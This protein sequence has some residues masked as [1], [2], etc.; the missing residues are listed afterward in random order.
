[1]I[2]LAKSIVLLSLDVCCVTF[3]IST[4]YKNER[5]YYLFHFSLQRQ[6]ICLLFARN[7]KVIIRNRQLGWRQVPT[8]NAA[9][10]P[11]AERVRC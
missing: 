2:L 1:M 5:K 3:A 4:A 6:R 10:C 11:H 7:R 8:K 9:V